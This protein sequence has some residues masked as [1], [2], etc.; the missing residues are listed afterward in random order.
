MRA[1]GSVQSISDRIRIV[2]GNGKFI[3]GQFSMALY[4]GY[5][6]FFIAEAVSYVE[7][8]INHY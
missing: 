2:H 8:P 4:N 7:Y 3:G 1:P 6:I 5:E